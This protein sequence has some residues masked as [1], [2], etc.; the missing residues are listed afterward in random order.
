MGLRADGTLLLVTVDGRTEAGGGMTLTELAQYFLWLDAT[1]A[2]N[3]DGGGSTT[4]WLRDQSINGIVSHPSDNG[5]ADHW[6]ERAVSDGLLLVPTA[7]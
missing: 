7:R 2:A 3:L 6:G 5:L 1:D 4:M